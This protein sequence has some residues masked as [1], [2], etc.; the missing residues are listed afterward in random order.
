MPTENGSNP[1]LFYFMMSFTID[2]PLEP[3]PEQAE[4]FLF[5]CDGTLV[6][7]MGAHHQGWERVLRENGATRP[8]C[9]DYFLSLG[10][11]SGR[12]VAEHLC[13]RTGLDCAGLDLNDMVRRKREL[14]LDMADQCAPIPQV[15]EF[16]RRVSR[17]HPVAVVSGGH[18]A[19]VEKTL[20]GA[21]I[22]DW[23]PV[24]VTPVDVKRGKPAP[25]MFLLAAEMLGVPPERCIV[26][27]DGQPGIE[28]ARAAGMRV[29]IVNPPVLE[30]ST[31]NP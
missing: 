30:V 24:V 13:R 22:R 7:T 26:F 19:A 9:F 18:R 5:D 27:E 8:L 16:A 6:D 10:G 3:L 25:D 2:E 15:I 14:F 20:L 29:V 28:G 23:F 4:A 12:E 1:D 21:G 11:L 31:S 17:S